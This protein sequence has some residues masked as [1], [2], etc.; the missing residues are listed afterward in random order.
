MN[1]QFF[2]F[3]FSRVVFISAFSFIILNSIFIIH[4]FAQEAPQQGINLNL[5]PTFL[6]LATDPGE[7]INGEFKLTNGNSDSENLKLGLV[8]YIN[9]PQ[10]T[11]TLSDMESGDNFADWLTFDEDSFNLGPGQ[12]KTVRFT[13]SPPDSASLGYYYGIL[14]SRSGE[15][16]ESGVTGTSIQGSVALPV[17]LQVNTPNA[18]REVQL[19][20]FK[21]DQLVYEHL[22]S[23]FQVTFENTGNVH[24]APVGD[25]FID[26][27]INKDVGL[28]QVNGSQGNILPGGVRTYVAEWADGFVVRVPKEE[29]G[30]VVV[31]DKGDREYETKYDFSKADKIR[32]GRYT[33][34]LLMVYDNGER[35]IPVEAQVSFWIFPWKIIGVIGLIIVLALVG[36]V[37]VLR[38]AFRKLRTKN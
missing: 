2:K 12:A 21:T 27:M 25:I 20:D 6:N 13:I 15:V 3:K 11:P 23:E 28:V 35:D 24:L 37:A 4:T 1:F 30:V 38:P 14:V 36:L 9:S 16:S 10:G 26:S 33:A 5:S 7:S 31:N 29:N 32:I 34:N 19:I 8:K 22:P 18:K 17:L